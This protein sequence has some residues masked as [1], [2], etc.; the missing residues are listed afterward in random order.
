MNTYRPPVRRAPSYALRESPNWFS[1]A[2]GLCYF[3][4]YAFLPVYRVLF[5]SVSGL[6]LASFSA[7]FAIPMIVGVLMCVAAVFFPRA[8]SMVISGC[9]ALTALVLI[10]IGHRA[11][12]AIS[13]L[14]DLGIF[15]V[16]AMIVVSVGAGVILCLLLGVLGLIL[17]LIVRPRSFTPPDGGWVF[18]NK[19]PGGPG[20][21]GTPGG[22]GGSGKPGGRGGSGGFKP[23]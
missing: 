23:F 22:F 15:D 7:L 2:C 1:A 11:V 19:G 16:A 4:A 5:T 12:S 21:P 10:F 13:D 17:E 9:G 20:G 3:L 14:S 18:K 6:R 8:V